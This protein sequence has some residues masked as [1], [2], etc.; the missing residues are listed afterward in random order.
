MTVGF[1]NHSLFCSCPIAPTTQLMLPSYPILGNSVNAAHLSQRSGSSVADGGL[2]LTQTSLQPVPFPPQLLPQAHLGMWHFSRE[3][4]YPCFNP[5]VQ[6][7]GLINPE[8]RHL[9]FPPRSECFPTNEGGV[10]L[11]GLVTST[12]VVARPSARTKRLEMKQ[13][14]K[15]RF[16]TTSSDDT[17]EVD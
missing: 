8:R 7:D 2:N 11:R 17:G 1:E 13:D 10:P 5:I 4:H 3:Q 12:S 6:F 9:P 14:T 15:R 16:S